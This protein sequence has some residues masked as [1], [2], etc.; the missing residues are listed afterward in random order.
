MKFADAIKSVL[1][2]YVTFKGRARRPEFWWW[3]LFTVLVS[4][5][6]AMIDR[7]TQTSIGFSSVDSAISLALLLPTLAV[8]VRRLHDSS[9]SG[10]WLLAP[11][12][13]YIG[14]SVL[15]L[16]GVFA[17]ILSA[18]SAG[19]GTEDPRGFAW[20]IGLGLMGLGGLV[21]MASVTLAL[22]LMVRPSTPG[23][24]RFGPFP[25]PPTHLPPTGGTGHW[26]QDPTYHP[27]P[28]AMPPRQQNGL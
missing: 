25:G 14:G 15:F 2:Q 24:N 10:W 12:G 22:V 7:V 21:M 8:A 11:I 13:V 5:A 28:V 18:L 9:L 17:F 3:Y 6:A 1:G 16:A 4:F 26:G 23:P 27:D 20:L 19:D